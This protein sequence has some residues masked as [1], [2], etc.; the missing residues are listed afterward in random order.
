MTKFLADV[1]YYTIVLLS[2]NDKIF[3]NRYFRD[4]IVSPLAFAEGERRL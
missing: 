4:E 3:R 1:I 2:A